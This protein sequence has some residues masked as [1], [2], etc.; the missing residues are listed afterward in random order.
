MSWL[1]SSFFVLNPREKSVQIQIDQFVEKRASVG[2]QELEASLAS[3]SA[4][5]KDLAKKGFKLMDSATGC[6]YIKYAES[7]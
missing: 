4:S 3:F 1:I 6:C 5:S 2:L 7:K